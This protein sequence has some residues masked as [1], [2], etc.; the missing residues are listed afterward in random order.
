M[1]IANFK[2]L[3]DYLNSR[4]DIELIEI[5]L[6]VQRVDEW[7]YPIKSIWVLDEP[8][9]QSEEGIE[10]VSVFEGDPNDEDDTIEQFDIY[11]KGYIFFDASGFDDEDTPVS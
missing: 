2:E 9:Y 11:P 7:Y 4:E 8:Y 5:P 3:K 6:G 10:P 1:K